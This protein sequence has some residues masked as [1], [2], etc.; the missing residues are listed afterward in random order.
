MKK[1]L[2]AGII[3]GAFFICGCA[4]ET[5]TVINQNINGHPSWVDQFITA[6]QA[7]KAENPPASV[8]Q[9]AYNNET[10]YY[11]PSPC[12]DMYN[13]LYDQDKNKICAPSGGGNGQGDGQC[14]DFSYEKNNCAKIWEDTRTPFSNNSNINE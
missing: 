2:L 11:V 6:K 13:N 5:A 14:Q 1:L 8:S 7:A 10:V 12:C 9:C 4:K 3:V